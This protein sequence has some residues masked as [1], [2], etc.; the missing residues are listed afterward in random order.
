MAHRSSRDDGVQCF[1]QG[2]DAERG[3]TTPMT[4][5]PRTARRRTPIPKMQLCEQQKRLVYTH[6]SD[7]LNSSS[8]THAIV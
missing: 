6:I 7:T 8:I 2:I 3:L 4:P 5:R 1:T